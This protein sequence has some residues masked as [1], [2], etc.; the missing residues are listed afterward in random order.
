MPKTGTTVWALGDSSGSAES[1][2]AAFDEVIKDPIKLYL[3][4]NRQEMDNLEPKKRVFLS[5][6]STIIECFIALDVSRV[7]FS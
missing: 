5:G 3:P 7:S 2:Q 6:I 4:H 1:G